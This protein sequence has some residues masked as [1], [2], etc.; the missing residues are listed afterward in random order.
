MTARGAFLHCKTVMLCFSVLLSLRVSTM[1]EFIICLYPVG[2]FHADL[3]GAELVVGSALR[4]L[5]ITV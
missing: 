3:Q 1:I 4:V 5:L 2:R